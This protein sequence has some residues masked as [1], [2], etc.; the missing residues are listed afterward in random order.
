MAAGSERKVAVVTGASRGI[1]AGIA[2]ALGENGYKVY[3]TGRTEKSAPAPK[4]KEKGPSLEVTA[5]YIREAGGEAVPVRV[6]HSKDSEIVKLFQRVD[7]ENGGRLDLLVNNAFAAV[8]NVGGTMGKPFWEKGGGSHWDAVNL[9]GLRAHYV[10]STCAAPLMTRRRSG[11]IVNVSSWGGMS[12]IFDVAYGIGKAGM[13]RMAAD[14][15]VELRPYEVSAISL[16][17]GIVSTEAMLAMASSD[18]PDERGLMKASFVD[19]YGAETPL[20]VGRTLAAMAGLSQ[21]ELIK[22]SGTVQLCGELGQ[23]FGVTDEE[24]NSPASF[25]SLR[26]ILPKGVPF[27]RGKEKSIPDI[28]IPWNAIKSG[29]ASPLRDSNELNYRIA[30]NRII[31]GENK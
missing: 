2:K 10:A 31:G 27:L 5:A 28:R 21:S 14:M 3:I 15:S 6:D 18:N 22:R 1:G 8:P 7:R 12:Y 13:D 26:W 30:S 16:W 4:T 19:L 29:V 11:L 23:E 24:G 17:P 20:Y 9:V 25:R